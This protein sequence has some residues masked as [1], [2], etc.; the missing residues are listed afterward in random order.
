[1][2]HNGQHKPQVCLTLTVFK[3]MFVR[4]LRMYLDVNGKQ[5]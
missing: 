3:S 5:S 2:E 4:T 1:M